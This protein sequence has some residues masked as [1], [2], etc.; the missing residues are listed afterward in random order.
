MKREG[1]LHMWQ[2]GEH[3]QEIEPMSIEPV[4]WAASE[5]RTFDPNVFDV[6][7]EVRDVDIRV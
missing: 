3:L 2:R 5:P 4:S 6:N 7:Y 1:D